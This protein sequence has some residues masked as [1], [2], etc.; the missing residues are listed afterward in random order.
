M[1]LTLLSFA[2]AIG[3]LVTIHELGHYWVA[4]RCG[5]YIE[6][7]SIGFGKVLY[8]RTDKRGCEWAVS[9]LPLGGYVMMRSQVLADAPAEIKNSALENK[10]LAQRAAIT[11]AGPLAN[12]ILAIVIYA[13]IGLIGT[14]EPAA[15]LGQ[16]AVASAAAQAGIQAGDTLVAVDHKPVKSWVQARWQLFDR[17]QT[18]GAVTLTLESAGGVPSERLLHLAPTSI[19]GD[20]VDPM[21]STGLVLATPTPYV[22]ETVAGSAGE[23]AGLQAG[24]VLVAINHQPVL[25]A[26]QFVDEIKPRANQTIDLTIE[27]HGQ[28]QILPVS[29]ESYTNEQGQTVGRIGILLGANIPMVH[30]RYGPI[31]S[32][33]Q[34]F[35]RTVDTFWLSLKMIGRMVTGH[36]SVKNISGP[37]S[38]ADY[39]GQ[40]ARVGLIAYLNFLALISIS[41]G[42]LNLLPIPM[43]D[44]GHLLYY[45]IEALTG[46][47]VSDAIKLIGQRI[48]LGILVALTLL[49]FFNDFNRLLN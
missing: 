20:G 14:Q 43:L 18:G 6:R 10:T 9:A 31:D 26:A 16:P 36:V 34:G 3:L 28:I 1:L 30:V 48:G 49:A 25:H 21:L 7:F 29:I 4:R 22:R 47:P 44:G 42:L 38:I 13:L 40:S 12:L 35:T 32:I 33:G 37:V 19:E 17:V 15:V 2:V 8:K 24:D 39:A 45:A 46:R 23:K 11:V 5:V 41:I 27:R